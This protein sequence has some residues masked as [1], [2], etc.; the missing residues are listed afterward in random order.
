MEPREMENLE[1]VEQLVE[2]AGCTYA[3][4]KDALEYS[5][6]NYSVDGYIAGF[7]S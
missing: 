1:K 5:D 6:W 3:E 2:K 7:A 4:A